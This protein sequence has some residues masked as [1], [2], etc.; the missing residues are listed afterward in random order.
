MLLILTVIVM[1]RGIKKKRER[2]REIKLKEKRKC[3]AQYSCSPSTDQCAAMHPGC[4]P[5]QFLV[6]LQPCCWQGLRS[7]KILD[8]V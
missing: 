2:E 4:V 8:L 5:S 3:D 1:K 7:W 6:P